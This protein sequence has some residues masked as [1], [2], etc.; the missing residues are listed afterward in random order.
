MSRGVLVC[1]R[2]QILYLIAPTAPSPPK[3]L[4]GSLEV[5]SV[6]P[7]P[8]RVKAKTFF[9]KALSEAMLQKTHGLLPAPSS[10]LS[11]FPSCFAIDHNLPLAHSNLLSSLVALM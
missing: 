9:L 7:F 8:A 5:D 2:L 4:E 3:I 1:A 10:S 11:T 6:W